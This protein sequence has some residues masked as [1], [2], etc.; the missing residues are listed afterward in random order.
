[1]YLFTMRGALQFDLLA[2]QWKGIFSWLFRD[3]VSEH[4][5]LN[6]EKKSAQ[7]LIP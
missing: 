4:Q 7:L 3:A 2:V 5:V 1:M 6:V